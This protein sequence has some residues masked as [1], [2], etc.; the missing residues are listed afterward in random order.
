MTNLCSSPRM[1][2]RK[3]TRALFLFAATI[4][5]INLFY[6][7][8]L[9][10]SKKRDQRKDKV[11]LLYTDFFKGKWFLRWG[12]PYHCKYQCTFT[13]KKSEMGNADVV[14]FHDADMPKRLPPRTK[15]SQIW[16][17]FNLESPVNSQA[18]DYRNVFNWSMSYR[19]DSDIFAPYG[20]FTP[21]DCKEKQIA[22]RLNSGRNYSHGKTK[23]IAWISS[24]CRD[25]FGRYSYV[26]ALSKYIQV[27]IFGK[28]G[29]HSCPTTSYSLQSEDCKQ[30]LRQYKFYLA[31]ENS[32]CEDYVTEKYWHVGLE[33]ELVPIVLGG[34]D[35]NNLA[36]P[37]SFI[38]VD[39]FDSVKKLADYLIYLNSSHD[40]YNEFF[41]WKMLYKLDT[42]SFMYGCAICTALQSYKA[43]QTKII[44][45]LHAYWK[46]GKCKGKINY[47]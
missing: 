9:T 38:N 33:N 8:S 2:A 34:A 26:N 45:S 23:M 41:Q 39:D 44:S 36:I 28:C 6:H 46:E 7:K 24:N 4:I 13:Y 18:R 22:E 30:Q 17:Y 15:M 5:I 40:A 3:S 32:L 1:A 14:A 31:F 37:G 21:L 16:V 25:T 27:D 10:S 11:I 35:Y 20:D 42:P 43:N 12:L 29:K 47:D 19:V